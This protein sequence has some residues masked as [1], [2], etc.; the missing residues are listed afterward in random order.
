[1]GGCHSRSEWPTFPNPALGPDHASG[2]KASAT[3]FGIS[4]AR[5]GLRSDLHPSVSRVSSP[6]RIA[7]V[8]PERG[9]RSSSRGGS[10]AGSGVTGVTPSSSR[11]PVHIGSEC[12]GRRTRGWVIPYSSNGKY[13]RCGSTG[14]RSAWERDHQGREGAPPPVSGSED[15]THLRRLLAAHASGLL[16]VHRL[17]KNL[18]TVSP[19]LDFGAANHKAESRLVT[20]YRSRKLNTVRMACHSGTKHTRRAGEICL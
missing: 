7:L 19:I 14:P 12:R 3:C 1:M 4:F 11:S 6:N 17:S 5:L 10:G 8:A 20:S 13:R 9:V 18:Y 15:L 2:K 16:L